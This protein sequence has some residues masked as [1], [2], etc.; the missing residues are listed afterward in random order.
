MWQRIK[1]ALHWIKGTCPYCFSLGRVVAEP[2]APPT[3]RY[4][5]PC[6]LC[7]CYMPQNIQRWKDRERQ[8]AEEDARDILERN[9][10]RNRLARDL[11]R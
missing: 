6:P 4:Y 5:I 11:P 3:E 8:Y 1:A 7:E 10:A 9:A 2:D